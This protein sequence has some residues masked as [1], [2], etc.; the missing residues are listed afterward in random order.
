MNIAMTPDE[1]SAL[2]GPVIEALARGNKIEAI[3]L[4][5]DLRGSGLKESKDDVDAYIESRP[6]LRTRFA[7]AAEQQSKILLKWVVIL[8]AIAAAVYWFGF[9]K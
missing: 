1:K 5:R 9:R 3:K 6:D 7:A 2:P 4:L 8:A